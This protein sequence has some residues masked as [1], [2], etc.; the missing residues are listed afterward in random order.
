MKYVALGILAVLA[1]YGGYVAT[2]RLA[3]EIRHAIVH[4]KMRKLKPCKCGAEF[5][6]V[7]TNGHVLIIACD[8]CGRVVEDT[9]DEAIRRWND[10][11]SDERYE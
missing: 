5:K 7:G 2:R 10:G 3:N 11:E 9:V 1:T 6:D 4:V 8:E